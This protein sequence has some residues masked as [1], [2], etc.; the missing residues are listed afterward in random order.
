MSL[1]NFALIK[2]KNPQVKLMVAAGGWTFGTAI[3]K[4]LAAS[5]TARSEL[6]KNAVIFL[7]NY[8][9]DGF[10]VDWE[11]PIGDKENFILLLT[12]LKRQLSANNLLLTVAV[13]AGQDT[14]D[15]AYDIP[16][17]QAQVDF[18][19]L[20]TYDLHQ[21]WEG[22]TG[23]N[24]PLFDDPISV[25]SC[26]QYWLLRGTPRDKLILGIPSYGQL[27]TLADP[28]NNWYGAPTVGGT[29]RTYSE[30]CNTDWQRTW[31]ESKQ[32]P[33]K[34]NGNQWL[35]YDDIQS[36]SIKAQYAKNQN[37]GGVMLWSLENDDFAGS[38]R[39]GTFPITR[40]IFGITMENVSN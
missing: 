35:G 7:K 15:K 37:L 29:T 3:F 14:S 6:A 18:I 16:R 11:Y 9:L 33:I 17:I 4:T 30:I 20:M 36:V 39:Q 40:T 26:V 8:N 24:A 13:A 21:P 12:D 19:N 1:R 38:C 27:F 32:V 34:I 23:H 5:P 28:K 25:D 2:S 22:K 31:L 10:D